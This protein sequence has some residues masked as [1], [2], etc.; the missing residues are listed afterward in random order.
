MSDEQP[1]GDAL[2][3]A[4]ERI[5]AEHT[6]TLRDERDRLKRGGAALGKSLDF[7]MRLAQQ[8]TGS[9]DVIQDDGDGDWGVVAERLAALGARAEA[10]EA[11]VRRLR[12][13]RA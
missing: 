5:L 9:D 13:G 2:A 7:W 11:E 6:Q 12:E 3:P 4:V 8:V 1:R 10:A